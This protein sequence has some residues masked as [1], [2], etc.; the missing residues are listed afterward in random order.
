M[1]LGLGT[2][3]FGL[4]YGISNKSGQVSEAEVGKILQL[5]ASSG[6]QI[7]DTAAGYGDSEAVLG[8]SL[9]P[10]HNFSIVTKTLPL[11]TDQVR[12]EDVARAETA[13]YDSLLHLGQPSVYGLLVHNSADLLSPGGERLYASLQR[14]KSEGLVGKIGVSVYGKDEVDRLFGQYAFDLVQ[15]P[16]NV[17]DQQLV[18]NG[19]L[20]R[21]Y[22][23]GVEIHVRSALLQGLLLMPSA[24]LPPY[25]ASIKLHHK[26]Y[27]AALAQA[28]VSP[29]AGALGYFHSRPEVST[30]LVGVETSVQLQECLVATREA[31]PLNFASFAID[32]PLMLDPR[33]WRNY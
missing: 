30:V 27:L 19:T 17:F 21:L 26:A 25:F 12:L 13:F 18:Q 7:L 9:A 6:M 1:R 15:L 29:L 20:Q 14:W 31:P 32:D 33:V 24:A 5:A 16:L 2:V 23:A 8:A 4:P 22:E 28:G 11:K 3:Q 10:A